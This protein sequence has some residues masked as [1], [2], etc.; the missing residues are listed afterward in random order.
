MTR[1]RLPELI[2]IG[3]GAARRMAAFCIS[4]MGESRGGES[5]GSDSCLR[6]IAD[7]STWAAMG[8]EAQRELRAVGLSTRATVFDRACL[9]ADA[10]SV[11]RLLIDDDPSERLYIAIS[12]PK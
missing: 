1:P 11:L 10:G 2:D 7:G 9:A 4:R 6:L 8:E 12:N 5:R 3:P